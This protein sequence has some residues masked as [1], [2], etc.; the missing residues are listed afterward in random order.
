MHR[1]ILLRDKTKEAKK[2]SLVVPPITEPPKKPAQKRGR[3][4]KILAP[5][6]ETASIAE[7]GATTLHLKK[8]FRA[9][10][11]ATVSEDP[12]LR[13][14]GS[15]TAKTMGV[16]E[17]RGVPLPSSS[18]SSKDHKPGE[19]KD[20]KAIEPPKGQRRD[21]PIP[22]EQLVKL[23]EGSTSLEKR[24]EVLFAHS[25]ATAV[26]DYTVTKLPTTIMRER[27]GELSTYSV[28]L[29]LPSSPMKRVLYT[30]YSLEGRSYL[31]QVS[32][33][34]AGHFHSQKTPADQTSFSWIKDDGDAALYFDLTFKHHS[35][36]ILRS[37]AEIHDPGVAAALDRSLKLGVDVLHHP[38]TTALPRVDESELHTLHADAVFNGKTLYTGMHD[39]VRS[40]WGRSSDVFFVDDSKFTDPG[41]NY[42]IPLRLHFPTISGKTCYQKYDSHVELV[43]GKIKTAFYG[44]LKQDL[45]KRAT[46]LSRLQTF[47]LAEWF[48]GLEEQA[49][50]SR[51]LLEK[52]KTEIK[53]FLSKS[54]T[55]KFYFEECRKKNSDVFALPE[56]IEFLKNAENPTEYLK[57]IEAAYLVCKKV[58]R[59]SEWLYKHLKSEPRLGA[60]I[61]RKNLTVDNVLSDVEL[62]NALK[63]IFKPA[64]LDKILF[65]RIKLF[66]QYSSSL[67]LPF[68]LKALATEFYGEKMSLL[69]ANPFVGTTI[70]F[71][72]L[73]V[74]VDQASRLCKKGHGKALKEFWNLALDGF[75]LGTLE[76]TKPLG[77]SEILDEFKG[78]ILELGRH[79]YVW[80]IPGEV[81]VEGTAHE[82]PDFSVSESS[83]SMGLGGGRPG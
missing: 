62:E 48:K 25:T 11:K 14:E 7:S 20:E 67:E 64:A 12:S 39:K 27:K 72:Q 41:D 55:L 8:R 24:L 31:L 77:L 70:T 32:L 57:K 81:P 60:V 43:V 30:Q 19:G 1:S 40:L 66:E 15:P 29:K 49:T 16:G 78:C 33:T 65:K 56:F 38:T 58:G 68:R 69:S 9:T 36:I 61:K 17:V 6:D 22:F 71:S 63:Q 74:A 82:D 21:N 26:S 46:K 44:M 45:K 51:D 76:H 80:K 52:L 75:S 54:P 79:S 73:A 10:E 59:C 23:I 83:S 53:V 42:R 5:L 34:P 35:K 13:S 47:T 37:I 18:S 2:E 3:P 4:K 50:E 28:K